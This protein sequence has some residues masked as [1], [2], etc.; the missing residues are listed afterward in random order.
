MSSGDQYLSQP[1]VPLLYEMAI[2]FF[3]AARQNLDPVLEAIDG[4]R[5]LETQQD[6]RPASP[7]HIA[8]RFSEL[9][10]GVRLHHLGACLAATSNLG[11]AYV[12]SFRLLSFLTQG[13]DALPPNAKRP[14]LAKL[15]DA[16]PSALRNKLSQ[17]YEQT[18]SHDIELEMSAE[19]FPCDEPNDSV[20][21]GGKGFRAQLAYWQ[22]RGLLHEGHV[23]LTATGG[24]RVLR[25]FIPLRSVLI[26]DSILA[27]QVAPKL[28]FRYQRMNEQLSSRSENPQL[29][30]DGSSIYVSLPDKLGRTLEAKWKPTVTSVVRIR[31]SE[32]ES[33]SPGFETPFNWC[34]FLDLKPDTEYEVQLTHK[35][36]VGES[37]P[38]ISTIRTKPEAE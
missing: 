25:F 32:T 24:P 38:A 27:D 6:G 23:T 36:D 29:K 3:H 21:S 12:H 11:L 33:W 18:G 20:T 2:C 35:N 7:D 31:E 4:Y 1:L 14:N 8:R 10:S 15:Y 22:S 34:T 19:P 37:Q 26:L 5:E 16:L 13:T 28:G 9:P 30:W 17:I